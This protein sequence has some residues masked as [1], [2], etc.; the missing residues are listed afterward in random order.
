MANDTNDTAPW[1]IKAVPINVREKAVRHARMDGVTVAEWLARA[2][3]TQANRR[4]GNVVIA[5]RKPEASLESALAAIDQGFKVAA[6]LQAMAAVQSSG[7]P[8]SKAAAR[9]TVRLLRSRV[10]EA[11]GLPAL[12]S[13]QT[14]GQT[15]RQ[16]GQTIRQDQT[17]SDG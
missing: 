13:R 2:V 5:P 8:V 11:G 17:V 16:I 9:D 1:T 3:E 10:R 6:M 14:G 7:L 12:K 4:D 15:R